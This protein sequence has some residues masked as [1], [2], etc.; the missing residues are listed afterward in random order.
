MPINKKPQMTLRRGGLKRFIELQEGDG[1]DCDMIFATA[2]DWAVRMEKKMTKGIALEKCA[3]QTSKAAIK[4]HSP[5]MSGCWFTYV[6]LVLTECW[7]HGDQLRRWEN[8]TH[9]VTEEQAK[10]RLIHGALIGV[11]I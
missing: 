4:T 6:I 8:S 7:K 2:D 5:G 11:S 1:K 10:G 9:G 3:D